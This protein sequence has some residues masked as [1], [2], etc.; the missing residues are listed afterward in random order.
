[1]ERPAKRPRLLTPL[2]SV[3]AGF[4]NQHAYYETPDDELND[5]EELEEEEEDEPVYDPDQELQRKRARVDFKLK[6]TFEAIFEKYGRDFEGIGDEIDMRTG[7]VVVNNGHLLE[8]RHEMDAGDSGR[9]QIG[10]R[11]WSEEEDDDM[12]G[13]EEDDDMEDEN[14]DDD[15][16]EG[17][18]D[19][20]DDMEE[21]EEDYDD[22]DALG[23]GDRM[24]EDDLILR[25]FAQASQQ[26]KQRHP[27]HESGPSRDRFAVHAEPR[28]R[29]VSRP[30][31][32]GSVI[33]SRSEILAQF[34]PQLGPEIAKYVSKKGLE[35]KIIEPAW[36]V[37]DIVPMAPSPPNRRP[38]IKSMVRQ[39]SPEL[40]RSPS[41]ENAISIWAVNTSKLVRKRFSRY[42]DNLLLD[43]VAD[44]RRQ[45][46]NL[47]SHLTWRQLEAT[48]NYKTYPF[49]IPLTRNRTLGMTGTLGNHVTPANL[50]TFTLAGLMS[51]TYLLL[52]PQ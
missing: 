41:P 52:K 2:D 35:D 16:E 38:L 27:P 39:P 37:P 31:L 43:F 22:E 30:S 7:E 5:Y 24:E 4:G 34:G 8:M 20:D 3:Y 19:D 1:M 25:G 11:S 50:P 10:E 26:F 23:D 49:H 33:P 14:D 42:D 15:Q 17:D 32:P 36:R 13:S 9:S 6:S 28:H 40:E 48:V 46:L 21:D 51:L 12:S 29:V 47:S 45:G 44:A 18:D